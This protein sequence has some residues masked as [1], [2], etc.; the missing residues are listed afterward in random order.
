[1]TS[2]A[3]AAA[4][5]SC[6]VFQER[7]K[8]EDG[9]PFAARMPTPALELAFETAVE[10]AAV[11]GR[12][13]EEAGLI[14]REAAGFSSSEMLPATVG[15][16]VQAALRPGLVH[17]VHAWASGAKFVD[18]CALT[19]AMEGT[20]VRTVMRVDEVR[21]REEEEGEEEEK[22]EGDI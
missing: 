22:Q 12:A 16:W 9:D 5:L 20:I 8:D 11:V 4:L 14:G 15:E 13:H 6:Y 17:A 3:D 7:S 19:E 10:A 1:L 21:G 18:V 2:P